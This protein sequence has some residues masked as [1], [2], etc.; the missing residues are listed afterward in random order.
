MLAKIYKYFNNNLEIKKM[1]NFK[2]ELY[3]KIG[4]TIKETLNR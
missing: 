2:F 4:N 3:I 1:H